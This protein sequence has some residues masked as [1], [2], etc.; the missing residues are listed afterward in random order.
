VAVGSLNGKITG[1]WPYDNSVGWMDNHNEGIAFSGDFDFYGLRSNFTASS[2]SISP[3]VLAGYVTDR[4]WASLNTGGGNYT[5]TTSSVL[6]N[7][8]PAGKAVLPYDLH[9]LPI[10]NDGTGAIGAFQLTAR[11]RV[12]AMNPLYL[13]YNH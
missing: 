6:L 13:I 2:Q 11:A 7:R 10:P 3:S 9:G 4:S 12:G 1:T 5:P 8:I